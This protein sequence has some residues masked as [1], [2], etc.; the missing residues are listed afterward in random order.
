MSVPGQYDG[1][2]RTL[3][4]P[5]L[6]QKPALPG[7]PKDLWEKPPVFG[8]D[9]DVLT[10]AAEWHGGQVSATFPEAFRV[11]QLEPFGVDVGIVGMVLVAALI[12]D[13]ADSRFGVWVAI[14]NGER[15]NL[16]K[17]NKVFIGAMTQQNTQTGGIP[18][19]SNRTASLAFGEQSA[20]RT[21]SGQRLALY[22]TG[23]NSGQLGAAT[24]TVYTIS[25]YRAKSG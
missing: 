20:L 21:N 3:Q 24:L 14:D 15:I 19:P 18:N 2:V 16:N 10:A 17:A 11:A 6:Y 1:T 4:P 5:K 9:L 25:T 22:A 13:Q 7:S 8:Y 23:S 12:N